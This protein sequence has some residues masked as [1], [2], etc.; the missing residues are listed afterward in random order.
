MQ[1][2]AYLDR[3]GIAADDFAAKIGVD[4]VS[5]HRYLRGV[6]RP[7]WTVMGRIIKATSGEVTANDFVAR[8]LPQKTR[9]GIRNAC[10]AA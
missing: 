3:E 7:K 6:R 5:V 10:V 8:E 9:R 4:P 2:R 1:L